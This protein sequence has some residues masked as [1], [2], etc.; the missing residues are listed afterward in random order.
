MNWLVLL[1]LGICIG[2]HFFMHG[3]GHGSHGHNHTQNPQ[4]NK[5]NGEE[6]PS[7]EFVPVE[8]ESERIPE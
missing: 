3:R 4:Q 8:E 5:P 6:K 2:M 1:L 7:P